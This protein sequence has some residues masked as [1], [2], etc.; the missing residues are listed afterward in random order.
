MEIAPY[1]ADRDWEAARRIWREIGWTAP[2][3]ER[4][5]QVLRAAV[6]AG[7]A[8]VGRL[9]GVAECLVTD[10]VGTLC[11][12]HDDIPFVGMTSVATSHVARKRGLAGR[13]TA[14]ML[15][16]AAGDGALVAALGVFDQGFYNRIGFGSGPYERWVHMN[17][18]MLRLPVPAAR[19]I[20]LGDDDWEEI[21]ACRTRRLRRHG[22]LT[23][24]PA[25]LT[26]ADMMEPPRG[27][28]LGFRREP[29]GLLTHML[30]LRAENMEEGPYTVGFMAYETGEQLIGLL[31]VIKSLEDQINEVR[32][33]EP[34]GLQVQDLATRPHHAK[35]ARVFANA[36]W[37]LRILDLPGCMARTH[38][39][40]EELRLSVAVQDPVGAFLPDDVPW[41]GVEGEYV[42]TLGAQCS[43]E[44]GPD[45]NL[46]KLEAS[47]GALSRLWYGV[48]PATGLT[49]TDDLC[50]PP[51]LLE[52]LDR[53]FRL[54]R[55]SWDW[56]F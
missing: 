4:D 8:L 40:C 14:R 34:P 27:F 18:K 12:Q 17:P 47:V 1:D 48:R 31:G 43:A 29:D 50:G 13:V 9:D 20:R 16:E 24:A 7:R 23:F 11:H 41:R 26:R 51:E 10:A 53:A 25:A 5:E 15:A 19:P 38:L 33:V 56:Q 46:P 44:R 28:G 21:H 6:T 37:Q 36:D 55:P 22:A 2:D 54:P 35:S 3:N 52:A 49:L 39:D 42:L 30:W 45:P 32:F